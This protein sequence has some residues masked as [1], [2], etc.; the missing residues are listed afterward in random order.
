MI[1][2]K[3][4]KDIIKKMKKNKDIV[5][6]FIKAFSKLPS[7]EVVSILNQGFMFIIQGVTTFLKKDLEVLIDN[8][9]ASLKKDPKVKNSKELSD[10]KKSKKTKGDVKKASNFE[11]VKTTL[12]LE[13]DEKNKKSK[14][15]Y[16]I[17]KADSEKSGLHK[18]LL[19]AESIEHEDEKGLIISIEKKEANQPFFKVDDICTKSQ[20]KKIEKL[21]LL[22]LSND[23]KLLRTGM[24]MKGDNPLSII[25]D[26]NIDSFIKERFLNK[27]LE[28]NPFFRIDVYKKR[29][30][31]LISF[32]PEK[33]FVFDC[34]SFNILGDIY[35]NTLIQNVIELIWFFFIR[36][37]GSC[38]LNFSFIQDLDDDSQR[39]ISKNVFFNHSIINKRED[40]KFIAENISKSYNLWVD[41]YGDIIIK[42]IKFTII[43]D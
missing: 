39:E 9:I 13:K 3:T 25:P 42:N 26:A 6:N 20:K 37:S 16:T 19:K 21:N 35:L 1:E 4:I 15:V 24:C 33:S 14:K 29:G 34:N 38:W 17:K 40:F 36:K 22:A 5:S 27:F 28:N 32:I 12:N 43:V 23:S 2:K 11:D 8:K 41:E 30:Y 18:K 31:I 10:V 7:E